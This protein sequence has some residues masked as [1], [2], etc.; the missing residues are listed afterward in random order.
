MWCHHNQYCDMSAVL[1]CRVQTWNHEGSA[2]LRQVQVTGPGSASESPDQSRCVWHQESRQR[3]ARRSLHHLLITFMLQLVLKYLFINHWWIYWTKC[4]L[5][6]QIQTD[7]HQNIISR[8]ATRRKPTSDVFSV[9]F[10]CPNIHKMNKTETK[11]QERKTLS[12][13]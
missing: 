8:T 12:N 6:N 11:K 13:A 9:W 10:F 3:A 7:S 4:S 1:S 2:V 5:I